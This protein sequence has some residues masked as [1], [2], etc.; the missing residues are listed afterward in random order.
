M[1]MNALFWEGQGIFSR[2]FRAWDNFLT[3][4]GFGCEIALVAWNSAADFAKNALEVSAWPF[5]TF[6]L[7]RY[8]GG[9]LGDG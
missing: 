1:V 6:G 3:G 7:R 8:L 4:R 5:C 2:G 9:W